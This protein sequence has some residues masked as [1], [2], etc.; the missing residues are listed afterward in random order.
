MT[1]LIATI[2]L[3]TV[4]FAL[5]KLFPKFKIDGLQAIVVNYF[6]C[7]ITGSIFLEKFPITTKSLQHDWFPWA[8]LMGAMFISL[9]NLIAWRTKED[10]MTTTTI[11]NKLSLVIPV[12]FSVWLYNEQLT[13]LKILGILIAAP[14]VYFT[15]RADNSQPRS[16]LFPALL[17]VGSGL[18]DTLVKYVED[19]FLQDSQE[20]AEYTI[21]LFATAAI[22][23]LFVI[24][25]QKLRDKI[26]LHGRNM[27]AGIL[28]GGP[29]YFS[30]YFLIRL[31][32]S[33]FLQSS[34]AIPV[35]NIGIVLLSAVSAIVFFKEKI[36]WKRAL[37]LC[38]SIV[39]ILLIAL[40]DL[41]G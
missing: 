31:L 41:Y 28:L 5:F 13:F 36:T 24:V 6:V 17:F 32:H 19:S 2:L 1:Y 11:A 37:G 21:H 34:S 27:V 20:Q 25:V 26:N 7:V 3:N 18:L 15:T 29:N 9:F 4:L 33:D 16:I 40:S 30:I 22:I 12:L 14:A 39:A 8:L 35:N 38:L 10:G 23:G